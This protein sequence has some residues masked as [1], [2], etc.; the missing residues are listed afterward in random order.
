M[1]ST[2]RRA[3]LR[4]A[5]A[6]SATLLVAAGADGAVQPPT[7]DTTLVAGEPQPSPREDKPLAEP[8]PE[9]SPRGDG[10]EEFPRTHPGRGG[11]I[12]TATDRGKLV[13]GLRGADLPPVPV[14]TPDLPKLPWTMVGGVKEFHLIAEHVRREFLPNMWFDCW[15]YNGT[16][17]GPMIEAVQGD[18]VRIVVHNELPEP[19]TVHWHGLELPIRFDGVPGITQDPIQPGKQFAYEFDLHQ[20]GTFF[21]HSHGP[22]QEIMGM[23]GLFIIHPREAYLPRVDHDFALILNEF[24]IL[25]QNTIPNSM[26]MEVNFFTINGRSGPYT[27]PM[28]VRLG[29]RVRIRFMNLSPIDHHP[30]HLHGHTF[31]IT[32][33]EGGRIP[34]SAWIPGNTVLV[35]VA[36]ARDVEFVANNAGDWML[37]CHILHHMMNHMTSMT[38]P[39]ITELARL[40]GMPWGMPME[41]GLGMSPDGPALSQENGPSLGHGMGEQTSAER[42][43]RTGPVFGPRDKKPGYRVPGFPQDMMGMMHTM[44]ETDMKKIA[45]PETRGMRRNWSMGLE[46]MMT[47]VR[48]LPPD[49]YD[50]VVASREDIEP[51][52]SVPG[53][54]P[55]MMPK[56]QH[57]NGSNGHA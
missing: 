42:E 44:S 55:G 2:T 3:F 54:G 50:A 18:R 40:R 31:W 16:M 1:D 4:S 39:S 29:N 13:S 38:G 33:T 23:M 30:M 22:M 17:P 6:A 43:I 41:A 7:S 35:G 15:G 53:S 28:L 49:L 25:P 46:A 26:S 10:T 9:P 48:V 57:G 45:K 14:E 34:E 12:G 24:S 56:M 11:P 27:T 37:H 47:T 32:G 52:A 36:Q 20:D 51:G 5:T 21:Y 8:R 19:T